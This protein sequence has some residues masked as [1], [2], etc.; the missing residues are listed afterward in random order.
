MENEKIVLE[1]KDIDRYFQGESLVADQSREEKVFLSEDSWSHYLKG[2]M[3]NDQNEMAQLIGELDQLDWREE[4]KLW[5]NVLLTGK[6]YGSGSHMRELEVS[7]SKFSHENHMIEELLTDV[8]KML[9]TRRSEAREEAYQ[10]EMNKLRDV[11]DLKKQ[12]TREARG[13]LKRHEKHGNR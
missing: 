10:N 4:D 7:L 6:C 1:F 12:K 3:N 2:Y 13:N 8:G 5:W 11:A 9:M